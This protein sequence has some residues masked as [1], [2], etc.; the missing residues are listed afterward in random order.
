MNFPTHASLE[1]DGES[2]LIPSRAEDVPR[3][4]FKWWS[5]ARRIAAAG[6]YPKSANRWCPNNSFFE[7]IPEFRAV[8]VC[9]LSHLIHSVSVLRLVLTAFVLDP[10]CCFHGEMLMLLFLSLSIPADPCHGAAIATIG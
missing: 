8:V 5:E 7:F 4:F 3:Q 6:D 10:F 9:L 1:K 2:F